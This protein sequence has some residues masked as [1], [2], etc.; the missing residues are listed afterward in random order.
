MF[1]LS[2]GP[3]PKMFEGDVSMP[4]MI[5]KAKKDAFKIRKNY[6]RWR[7]WHTVRSATLWGIALALMMGVVFFIGQLFV[8][9][10][11]GGQSVYHPPLAFFLIL[12]GV[13]GVIVGYIKAR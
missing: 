8:N 5:E 4:R 13:C 12:G 10:G 6:Y 9:L 2:N 7:R 1:D 11:G 3:A